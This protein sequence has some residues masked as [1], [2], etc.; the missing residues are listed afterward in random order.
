MSGGTE[1]RRGGDSSRDGR[2]RLHLDTRLDE[3]ADAISIAF[4][5][6]LVGKVVRTITVPHFKGDV[7]IDLDS[8]DNV[9]GIEIIAVSYHVAPADLL[10]GLTDDVR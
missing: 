5:E 6:D 3:E 1:S 9:L 10:R 7:N 4:R 8:S 2:R